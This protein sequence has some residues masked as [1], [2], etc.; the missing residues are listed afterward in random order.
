MSMTP[1]PGEKVV[2]DKKEIDKLIS[3]L[4]AE[5]YQ[6]VGPTLGEGAV[7]WGEIDAAKDLPQGWGDEEE[8]GHYRLKP[9]DSGAYFGFSKP[10]QGMKAY[11]HPSRRRLW[12]A[13][14]AGAGFRMLRDEAAPPRYAF[15][16][17]RPCELAAVA[18][19]DRVFDNGTFTDPGY[20][21][22]RNEAFVIVAACTQSGA[23]CFC[24]SMETGPDAKA[25]YDI[26]LVEMPSGFIADAGS[27]RGVAVLAKLSAKKASEQ[28][29]A[30]AKS[31]IDQAAKSQKRSMPGDV[32][33]RLA[34]SLE[35]GH[36]EEIAKRCLT[37]GNCTM[38]CPT[39][40][41]TTVEDVTDLSGNQAERWRKWD[42]CFSIDYSYIHGGAVRTQGAS[43]Y[44]QW[45]THKLSHWHKQFGTSGCVGCG[46]CITWCPVGIDITQE[47]KAFE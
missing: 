9:S 11:L 16:G 42:S 17:A 4:K 18:V 38:V 27:E 39:C 43:R 41:C 34:K 47:A 44:R 21:A 31:Q 8:G 6:V 40:F 19:Q 23:T 2:L 20:F 26:K 29:Q 24:A 12:S 45:M 32:A 5:G 22:K 35:H 10:V 7:M 28:D 13:E 33:Q 14:R 25:G 1:S 36:W 46:R 15:L 30:A 3:V 37:C